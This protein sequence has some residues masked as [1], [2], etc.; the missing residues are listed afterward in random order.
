MSDSDSSPGCIV[1]L[2]RS[3][4]RA[5][6]F[7]CPQTSQRSF[8]FSRISPAEGETKGTGTSR[9]R[10]AAWL[11]MAIVLVPDHSVT[12]QDRD[13]LSAAEHATKTC[14][15]ESAP[16]NLEACETAYRLNAELFGSDNPQTLIS[17][18]QLAWLYTDIG[19]TK[20]AL[21][22]AEN[23]VKRN[24]T[25]FGVDDSRTLYGFFNLARTYVMLNRMQDALAPAERVRESSLRVLGENNL[26]TAN[27][28][29]LLA[30]IY[31]NLN[32]PQDAVRLANQVFGENDP[33]TVQ[34]LFDLAVAHL[35]VLSH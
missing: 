23:A 20:E 32:R 25:V 15:S 14:E 18:N 35:R 19:R 1:S 28:L 30:R 8:T 31:L 29:V 6:C 24:T 21:V 16:A 12:A 33:A 13:K 34:S 26:L 3:H 11:F 7:K 2:L 4:Q 5:R 10:F 22:L 17:M 9:K 27:S